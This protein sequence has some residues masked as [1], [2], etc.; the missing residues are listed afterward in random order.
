MLKIFF[1]YYEK[2]NAVLLASETW[3]LASE[4]WLLAQILKSTKRMM[5]SGSLVYSVWSHYSESLLYSA[6]PSTS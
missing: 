5:V 6:G 3:L 2:E 1:Y 4:T